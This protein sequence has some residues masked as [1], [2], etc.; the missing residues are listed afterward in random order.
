MIQSK[1]KTSITFQIE[2]LEPPT[3]LLE[4]QNL[5]A[6]LATFSTQIEAHSAIEEDL[7]S[8]GY[9]SFLY[10]M[11]QAYAEH[12]P[13]VL[14]PDIIWLLI[15]QGFSNHVNFSKNTAQ[16][17]F[18]HLTKQ[19]LV[20]R[21]DDIRLGDS[22]SPWAESTEQFT[23]QI[24]KH[25]GKKLIEV[26]RADFSTTG[27]AERVASNITIMDAMKPYFEYI[28]LTCVCGIPKVTLEGTEEDWEQILAKLEHLKKYQL[29]W[30]VAQLKPII[31]EL[32]LTSKGEVNNE[33][34][35]NMFKV[36]TLEEY[37][38]PEFIDGWITTF[39]PYD[40][41]GNLNNFN[42]EK[43]LSV[44][45]INELPKEIVCVDF[46]YQVQDNSGKII[47]ETP[48]EYRAGF[49]GLKQYKEDFAL[50]PE[51]GW[52]VSYKAGAIVQETED[53]YM[54]RSR[55]YYNLDVFPQDLFTKRKW[56][57]IILN[58][59]NEI[60]VP[61]KALYLSFFML[62]VNGQLTTKA[63]MNLSLLKKKKIYV[64]VNGEEF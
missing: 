39:Y 59:K 17:V 61:M 8:Y 13:F 53:E 6:I 63:K 32:K 62:E 38:N 10:G 2:D 15:A 50:R 19:Q 28:V 3:E 9:H 41:K 56:N 33:F 21:N 24:E 36:H 14:S 64:S 51:I 20:I 30:W 48:M 43:H 35:M 55:T 42:K 27:S 26:L 44:N 60:D 58:F 31:E 54:E 4:E 49:F 37:G 16:D 34:W 45:A 11:Y 12:R 23:V 46:I 1:N 22:S 18:P 5:E 7:V 25:V 29:E 57:Q 40:R 52:A 47:S